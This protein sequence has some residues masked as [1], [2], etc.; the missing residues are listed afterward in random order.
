M[1][2]RTLNADVVI[3]GAGPAGC[4]LSYLLARSGVSVILVERETDLYREFRGYFFQ[5]LVARLFDQMRILDSLLEEVTHEKCPIL[6]AHVFGQKRPIYDFTILSEQP[7]YALIIDQ[8]PLLRFLIDR[9]DAFDNFTFYDGTSVVDLIRDERNV[10][11]VTAK[12]RERNEEWAIAAR[13]VVGADGRYSTIRNT[14]GIDPG[15]DDAA[16]DILWCKFPKTAVETDTMARLDANGIIL[17]IP[18]GDDIQLGWFIESGTYPAIR[19]RGIEWLRNQ[20]TAV[21]PTIEAVL[22]EYLSE[23]EQCTLLKPA[24]GMCEEWTKNGLLLIGDAAHVASPFG[25]QGNSLAIQDAVV[26]HSQIVPALR[27]STGPIHNDQLQPIQET[28]RPAVETVM[29]TQKTAATATAFYVKYRETV[30]NTVWNVLFRGLFGL[31]SRFPSLS[32]RQTRL[33]AFGPEPVAVDT[34]LFGETETP[35][36]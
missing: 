8:P 14:A 9:A 34:T 33:F 16:V 12:N 11:G 5:P 10:V 15:L 22:N 28:R 25:A 35:R 2:D 1:T 4:V 23:F 31:T 26:A 27:E 24:P 18:L 29:E 6:F 30:P 19:E 21:D 3:V 20:I 36:Q 13:L 32:R 17:Y 7:N